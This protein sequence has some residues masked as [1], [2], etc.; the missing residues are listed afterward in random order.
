M[1][2]VH[3][4]DREWI[5]RPSERIEP[6]DGERLELTPGITLVHLPGHFPGSSALWWHGGDL[7]GTSTASTSTISTASP[8]GSK[9]IGDARAAVDESL[10]RYLE[11]IS[12]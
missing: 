3:A 4:A 11:A 5:A 10:D 12:A 9:V 2:P 8:G 1:P 6:W 7:H